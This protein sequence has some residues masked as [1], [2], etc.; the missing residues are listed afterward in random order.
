M[1]LRKNISWS[2]LGKVF[3][4]TSGFILYSILGR[5][6]TKTDFGEF[7]YIMSIIIPSIGFM[8]FGM[9]L[10]SSKLLPSQNNN[11]IHKSFLLQTFLIVSLFSL[12]I[13]YNINNYFNFVSKDIFHLIFSIT[14]LSACLRIATDYFRS[15]GMFHIFSIFNSIG[16]GGGLLVWAI[17]ISLVTYLL[18]Q[19][20]L[21]INTIFYS[22]LFSCFISIFTLSILYFKKVKKSFQN[23]KFTTLKSVKYQNFFF[24]CLSLMIITTSRVLDE[25]I[26]IWIAKYHLTLEDVAIFA[27]VF[28]I[29]SIIYI[30]LSVIDISTPQMI[31]TYIQQKNK[32]KLENFIREIS[33]YRFLAGLI[34]MLLVV[35]FSKL[36]INIIFGEKYIYVYN[37]VNIT[38]LSLILRIS[39]GPCPQILLLTNNHNLII[40]LRV[41]LFSFITIFCFL[42]N[43]TFNEIVILIIAYRIFF[44]IICFVLVKKKIGINTI[45]SFNFNH[46]KFRYE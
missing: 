3:I 4:T 13:S 11:S 23:F 41:I 22:L 32:L 9:G 16:T 26:F 21:N 43:I 5:N 29:I 18:F 6:L 17:F 2:I 44:D 20:N 19:T 14:F 40:Y 1:N 39:L 10:I 34:C 33:L 37:L 31:S 45:P 24:I 46:K 36:L 8:T 30:P 15:I 7:S 35:L 12:I 38:A 25:S 27:I 42:K 28:K